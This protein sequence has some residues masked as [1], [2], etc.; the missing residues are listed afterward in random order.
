LNRLF[1]AYGPIVSLIW[2]VI[3]IEL[4]VHWNHI[5]GVYVLGQTGQL[6]PLVIG[7]GSM[8]A[9]CGELS[10]SCRVY[11]YLWDLFVENFS[12]GLMLRIGDEIRR[13]MIRC[14]VHI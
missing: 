12:R 4:M 6:I 7:I 9:V 2:S 13:L 3:G 5:S 10:L 1:N 14:L 11:T 8:G